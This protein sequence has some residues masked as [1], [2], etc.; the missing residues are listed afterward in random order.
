MKYKI[1]LVC[2]VVVAAIQQTTAQ[3]FDSVEI[4]TVK[5]T[6]TISMLA[7]FWWKYWCVDGKGWH[8]HHR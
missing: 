5:I 8:C 1:V 6:E 4:K 7:G 3:N 2:A